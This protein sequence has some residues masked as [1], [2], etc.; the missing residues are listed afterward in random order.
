MGHNSALESQLVTLKHPS[1]SWPWKGPGSFVANKD[2]L[3]V[4]NIFPYIGNSNPNW[5]IFFRG[6][7]TTN[8]KMLSFRACL[9]DVIHTKEIPWCHQQMD[10]RIFQT[11]SEVTFGLLIRYVR[12]YQLDTPNHY[13]MWSSR[14]YLPSRFILKRGILRRKN[15]AI[16]YDGWVFIQK[17]IFL[18]MYAE[19][20]S[21]Q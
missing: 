3:V 17:G 6:V 7:E 15:W 2:W 9:N 8:Q 10:F 16:V 4:W 12:L 18:S 21:Y 20:L 1:W 11:A 19:A 13:P 14:Q 5:L